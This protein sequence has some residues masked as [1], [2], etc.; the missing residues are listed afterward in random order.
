MSFNC[1]V[2]ASNANVYRV[3]AAANYY[4]KAEFPSTYA[5]GCS[6]HPGWPGAGT[7][8]RKR[9]ISPGEMFILSDPSVRGTSKYY[10][11]HMPHTHEKILKNKG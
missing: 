10:T 2:M 3:S 5:Y 6:I 4:I 7:D 11:R 1:T 9:P 8:E